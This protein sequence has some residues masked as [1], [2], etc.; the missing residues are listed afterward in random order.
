MGSSRQYNITS[1]CNS[2]ITGNTLN[3]FQA[4]FPQPILFDEKYSMAVTEISFP[5][6]M[7][8]IN[9]KNNVLALSFYKNLNSESDHKYLDFNRYHFI[10]PRTM[11][12][13]EKYRLDFHIKIPIKPA[14]Y[15]DIEN[16]SNT[17]VGYIED[18]YAA[19]SMKPIDKRTNFR[20]FTIDML[21]T[22]FGIIESL[23]SSLQ[24]ELKISTLTNFQ[25]NPNYTFKNLWKDTMAYVKEQSALIFDF[26]WVSDQDLWTPT[27]WEFWNLLNLKTTQYV[28]DGIEP[29]SAAASDY[30]KGRRHGY[31]MLL[32]DHIRQV[33]KVQSR[34]SNVP[35]IRE[36]LLSSVQFY[37]CGIFFIDIILNNGDDFL[38]EIIDEKLGDKINIIEKVRD[39]INM[40]SSSQTEYQFI[41]CDDSMME[42]MIDI[43]CAVNCD[44]YDTENIEP[45]VLSRVIYGVNNR[46]SM[47]FDDLKALVKTALQFHKK[48][49]LPSSKI[50]YIENHDFDYFSL[51]QNT[52]YQA[53]EERDEINLKENH[54]FRQLVL[55]REFEG[56]LLNGLEYDVGEGVGGGT[57]QYALDIIRNDENRLQLPFLKLHNKTLSE[58]V[59][60]EI[61]KKFFTIEV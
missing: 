16:F 13:D 56:L 11:F 51:H 26:P 27:A 25:L 1:I 14:Y 49:N 36:H 23:S 33:F 31:N 39:K 19:Q 15:P 7:C 44:K 52:M 45:S 6:L 29:D 57:G 46:I 59:I 37:L 18:K 38:N 12:N 60:N 24:E 17:C 21:N 28:L 61:K 30:L 8:N 32:Y 20:L 22:D 40:I 43:L 4:P 42:E 5:Q 47:F 41:K 3:D 48:N 9:N 35:D 50:E 2:D 54:I 10:E 55:G 53:L 34:G 58:V